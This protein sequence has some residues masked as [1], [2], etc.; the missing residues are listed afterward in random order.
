MTSQITGQVSDGGIL[1]LKETPQYPSEHQNL[2]RSRKAVSKQ[3]VLQWFSSAMEYFM[4]ENYESILVD[5]S[6]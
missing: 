1:F 5:P 4:E 2:S 3:S 6:R